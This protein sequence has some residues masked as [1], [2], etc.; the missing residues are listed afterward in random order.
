M[1]GEKSLILARAPPYGGSPPH[2]W[3]KDEHVVY[4]LSVRRFT[5]TCVGKSPGISSPMSATSVHPHMRGEKVF[6]PLVNAA[7]NG[8][9]PHA[10]GKGC[11]LLREVFLA[12][13][14]P[15]CVGKSSCIRFHQYCRS[16][17][18]HMRGEKLVELNHC[19]SANGSPPHAWGKVRDEMRVLLMIR[20][21]P[22]C[23]GKRLTCLNCGLFCGSQRPCAHRRLQH[24]TNM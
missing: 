20:F 17:H 23:V 21:T 24:I 7:D 6:I 10:W 8:S 22:T 2:A 5:P 13:F 12:R 15:T 18:P 9:P 19:P 1:R 3:G 14:T 16:V 4:S 11:V